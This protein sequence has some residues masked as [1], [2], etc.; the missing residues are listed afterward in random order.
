M[1]RVCATGCFV[2]KQMIAASDRAKLADLSMRA[3]DTIIDDYGEGAEL[4]GASLVYEV[5][6]PRGEGEWA[7]HG[8]FVSLPDMSP[9]H[10]GG[11]HQET[12]NWLLHGCLGEP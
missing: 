11:L 8:N 12:A 3:L 7:H 5:R 9:T 6:V 4:L 1:T 2:A 10:V